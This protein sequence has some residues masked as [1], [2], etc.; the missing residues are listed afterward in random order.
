[1]SYLGNPTVVAKMRKINDD[2]KL[3][4][5]N[6][7]QITGQANAAGLDTLWDAFL[8][9]HFTT[10]EN[11]AQKWLK[12]RIKETEV[13]VLAKIKFYQQLL[14]VR[15]A[16]EK[17]AQGQPKGKKGAANPSSYAE[18]RRQEQQKL[19]TKL[20]REKTKVQQDAAEVKR[21]ESQN[22]NQKGW[23]QA[24]KDAFKKKFAAAKLDWFNSTK[25]RGLTQRKIH[26]LYAHSISNIIK[27]LKK[28]LSHLRQYKREVGTLKMPTL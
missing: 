9:N 14:K 28:D 17:A 20:Q 21:L 2:V 11:W 26:E 6:A 19:T 16:A 12:D 18:Q 15:Q 3:E 1:M 5:K 25:A 7:A 23:N 4:L 27:N 8:K 22:Q 24:Q 13:E 10:V